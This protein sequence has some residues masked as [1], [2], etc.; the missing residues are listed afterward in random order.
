MDRRIK[1]FSRTPMRGKIAS[2]ARLEATAREVRLAFERDAFDIRLARAVYGA[3]APIIDLD[4]FLSRARALFPALNCG[5]CSTYLSAVL[6]RGVV[7]RGTYGAAGHTVLMVGHL[8]VDITAD[9]FGG[10]SVYVGT[11]QRPWHLDDA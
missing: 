5:L 6:G 7:R 11:L 1:A 3:Y 4:L 10:P 2:L 9:Q 8:I